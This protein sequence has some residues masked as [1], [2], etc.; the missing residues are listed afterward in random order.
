[1]RRLVSTLALVLASSAWLLP[2][3]AQAQCNDFIFVDGFE[4]PEN[5][6]WPVAVDVSMLGNNEP[7]RT[8]TLT[9]NGADPLT[10]SADG[11]FCFNNT[12][13]GASMYSIQI[14]EQPSAG[15][16]CSL[17][18]DAGIATGPV[19]VQAICNTLP[20]LWDQFDW[21]EANWN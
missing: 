12:T 18:N 13:P 14:I 6:D 2:V 17:D 3:T 5:N 16:V 11:V 20:T 7:G 4:A 1:M 9:L 21:D 8:L 19:V 10:I 15:N